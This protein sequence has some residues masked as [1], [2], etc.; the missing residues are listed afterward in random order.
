MIILNIIISFLSG[1][2][3][4][5][6]KRHSFEPSDDVPDDSNDVADTGGDD[7]D[8]DCGGDDKDDQQPTK[9]V[10]E[11]NDDVKAVEPMP[12]KGVSDKNDDVKAVEPMPTKDVSDKNDDVKAMEPTN[13]VTDV[14]KEDK[15]MQ[16]SVENS[17]SKVSEGAESDVS[18]HK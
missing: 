18:T 16:E 15:L 17:D 4:E 12:T 2:W 13:D 7:D 8:D 11:K 9:G 14:R 5:K 10:G 1:L 6:I 3:L